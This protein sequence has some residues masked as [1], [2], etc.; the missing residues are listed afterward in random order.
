[1]EWE[2]RMNEISCTVLAECQGYFI[3]GRQQ[4]ATP[5]LRPHPA[6]RRISI[7]PSLDDQQR[8]TGEFKL[9]IDFVA[10]VDTPDPELGDL[11]RNLLEGILALLAFSTGYPCILTNT[12]SVRRPGPSEGVYRQICFAVPLS[13]GPFGAGIVGPP[14]FLDETILGQLLTDKQYMV[15]GWYRAALVS[16]DYIESCTALLAALEPL[17]KHFPCEATRTETCPK[18]GNERV[19]KASIAQ[20]VQS[21]L[22]TKGGLSKEDARAIWKMRNDMAHGRIARTAEQRRAMAEVRHSLLLAV[23]RGLR[24]WLGIDFGGI[25]PEPQGGISYSDAILAVDYTVPAE[26]DDAE[27]E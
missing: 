2:S 13:L 5:A 3:V 27:R 22:T 23:A 15:L 9:E 6:L 12:P 25:P 11:A 19:L 8:E 20:R 4:H 17:A 16:K 24:I 7:D 18:C 26:E 1:M 21:F 10:N 14:P